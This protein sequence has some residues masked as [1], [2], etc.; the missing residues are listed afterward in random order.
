MCVVVSTDLL[1]FVVVE[2]KCREANR[3]LQVQLDQALQQAQDPNS[4]GNSL[5]AEVSTRT[6]IHT[7]DTKLS[8][9]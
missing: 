2:Q 1:R 9:L 5:F 6:H 4:K 8:L 3:E 7:F